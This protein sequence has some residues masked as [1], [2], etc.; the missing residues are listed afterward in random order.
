MKIFK[1]NQTKRITAAAGASLLAAAVVVSSLFNSTQAAENADTL[2]GIE[3]LRNQMAE[4]GEYTILEIVPDINASEIGYFFDGYEPILSEWDP[5]TLT[6]RSWEDIICSM[7]T[8]EK[9]REFITRKKLELQEYYD[10]QGIK[11]EVPVTISNV[12]YNDSDS[13]VEG[14]EEIEGGSF[15]ANGYFIPA[16]PANN[17]AVANGTISNLRD[18]NR[19]F[20]SFEYVNFNNTPKQDDVAYYRSANNWP[21]SEADR[22]TIPDGAYIYTMDG[23]EYYCIGTWGENKDTILLSSPGGGGSSG[24]GGNTGNDTES[25][26]GEEEDPDS[27]EDENI[28]IDEG[29]NTGDGEDETVGGDNADSN[30]SENETEGGENSEIGGDDAENSGS[31]NESGENDAEINDSATNN[32]VD[33]SVAVG[34]SFAQFNWVKFVSTTGDIVKSLDIDAA[35]DLDENDSSDS[36]SK[37][38]TDSNQD[39]DGGQNGGSD[40]SGSAQDD[41]SDNSGSGQNGGSDGD[42]DG[43]NDGSDGSGDGQNSGSDGSGGNEGGDSGDSD[44]NK[45]DDSDDNKDNDSDNSEDD[46]KDDSD[47][48]DDEPSEDPEEENPDDENKEPDEDSDKDAD[49]DLNKRPGNIFRGKSIKAQDSNNRAEQYYLVFFERIEEESNIAGGAYVVNRNTDKYPIRPVM[50]GSA[51]E[52]STNT[53]GQFYFVETSGNHTQT[54]HFPGRLLYCTGAFHNN[55][56]FKQYVINMTKENFDNFKAKVITMTPDDLNKIY[57]NGTEE[58]AQGTLPEFD[59]LYLNS[60]LRPYHVD[61]AGSTDSGDSGSGS[62]GD[63]T[64]GDGNQG[65]EDDVPEGGGDQSS[66]DAVPEG[67]DD[68]SSGDDVAGG[69]DDQGSGDDVTGD[70]ENQGSGDDVTGGN[71][72]G[73]S[74]DLQESDTGNGQEENSGGIQE[75]NSDDN[76]AGTGSDIESDEESDNSEITSDTDT[77]NNSSNA[78]VPLAAQYMSAWKTYVS[79]DDSDNVESD[80]SEESDNSKTEESATPSGSDETDGSA[81]DT[82]GDNNNDNDTIGDAGTSGDVDGNDNTSS[83]DNA[84]TDTDNDGTTGDTAGTDDDGTTSDPADTDADSTTGD[85]TDSD[86]SDD[87]DTTDSDETGNTDTD[88]GNIPSSDLVNNNSSY[89]G[90]PITVYNTSNSDLSTDVVRLLFNKVASAALPC[91]VDG[92]ILYGKSEGGAITDKSENN[93]EN[94]EMFRLAA[95]LCQPTLEKDYTSVSKADLLAGIEDGDKNFTTEQVYCR[96]GNGK[97]SIIND[98]FFKFTIYEEGKANEVEEGFQNVLDE[99]NLENLYRESDSSGQYKSLS[100]NIAQA[101]AVRHIINYQNR[102]NVDTKKKIKVLEIQPALTTKAELDL[103][104]IQK[105]APGVEDVETTIMTTSEF[106]G[107]IEKINEVYDLVYI[108]TSKEHLNISNWITDTGISSDKDNKYLGST[109]Y[110][111]SEMDGLIYSNIGDKRVVYLPMSGLLDSEYRRNYDG[112]T[113]YYNFVRYSGNDITKEKKDALISFLNG[114]YPI[115]ISDEFIEQPVTVFEDEYFGGRRATLGVGTY[116]EKD[117]LDNQVYSAANTPAKGISSIQVKEGYQVTLYAGNDCTG[118]YT[119]IDS[120]T[121]NLDNLTNLTTPSK[122]TWNNRIRSMSVDKI[123]GA[124]PVKAIDGNH[125]DNSSYLYEFVDTALKKKYTNFYAKGDIDETGSELF[126]FYLNRAKASLVN[127]SANGFKGKSGE[128]TGSEVNEA[129]YI[130]PNAVGRYTLQFNFTIQNEGAASMDTRYYCK[131]YIDVNADGKFSEFEEVSDIVML[132]R[133]SGG[134]VSPNELYAGTAYTITRDVPTGYKGLLPWKIEVCQVNNENIYASQQGYTKLNGLDKE[135][136]RICQITKDGNDVI[137]LNHEINTEGTYFYTLVNGGVGPDGKTYDGI[138]DDFELD[139][140]TI[141]ISEYEAE[142]AANAHY[143]DNFNMLILGFSD[144]Y[145]DFTGDSNSGAMGAIVDFINSGKSVLL[146]HDTTSFFNNPIIDGTELGWT[147][148]DST[149]AQSDLL[150]YAGG[151]SRF[152]ATLNKYVRPLVGMDRYGVLSSSIVK[153]GAALKDGQDGWGDLVNSTKDAAYKPKS[154]RKE[155]VPEAQGYTYGVITA[156]DKRAYNL[157][158]TDIE[159]SK[160][161]MYSSSTPGFSELGPFRNDY[162]S[163]RFDDSYYWDNVK[164]N[165]EM[166]VVNNGEVDKVHVTQVNQ[167]QIT[168]YPYKLDEEFEVGLTH[169]QYY[170]LDYTADDDGDKQSDLVV[171][172]CLGGRTSS[173]KAKTQTIYSQSPNDVRNNYYI[174]NKGNITYTGMGHSAGRDVKYTFNEAKLFINTMIASYQAGVKPPSITVLESGLPEA[175]QLTTMYRYYDEINMISLADAVSSGEY[176]RVYFTVRDLNFVKGTR[177]ID[178]KVY[179]H[180]DGAGGTD[181]ITI[182]GEEIYVNSLGDRIFDVATET[183]NAGYGLNSGDIYYIEVPKSI[184]SNCENGLDIYFEAQ[185]TIRTNTTNENVYTTGKVYAKLQVLRA[186]LFELD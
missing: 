17:A 176:E 154:G 151:D 74:D 181:I 135:I 152:A 163:Q 88:D 39:E 115:V 100:T 82:S 107:H 70:D 97:D 33:A 119:I 128:N 90:Y 132:N 72:S 150:G 172:Y 16:T 139:V 24:G 103:K 92:S 117:L 108:G 29:E 87:T 96:L 19:Y 177:E 183:M 81:T 41:D 104:Q 85:N 95:M 142:F 23:T 25:G 180:V 114:S 106:I 158:S 170:Q 7:D 136:L 13:Y 101:E 174:Y 175:S 131:L 118:E 56:W 105:W 168:E 122:L 94:T 5:E 38:V 144:M 153:R 141:N 146:A 161:N 93:T 84:A 169:S 15:D 112:R 9:R 48:N 126:K 49:K 109:I 6:W 28:D 133:N 167:G 120:K 129:Y 134:I 80:S 47:E 67:S 186:Y 125:I 124:Q 166:N 71:S 130:Y 123:E 46:K 110:N 55:E 155:S 140:T 156:K 127:F 147:Q 185:S 86:G 31:E 75:D 113:Y 145:G 27:G 4:G 65:S 149:N 30:G 54:Y 165:G 44:N 32:T 37:G 10:A 14:Y 60:G 69:G 68:Q 20:V 137:N 45:G 89:Y 148:R 58:Y 34:N 159:F 102:R 171:W 53:T 184:L 22:D 36:A 18:S 66:G 1:S 138:L 40:N 98:N 63:G 99:I 21:L 2:M 64:G 42:G 164:D 121:A 3:K 50:S 73:G 143:L 61:I 91:L 77:L 111:D 173:D 160:T 179:Y 11:A 83:N 26:N 35:A 162:A 62:G 57:Q 8:T 78:K 12:G 182:D 178:V 51:G 76:K 59:F 52:S 43:Q 79:Q 116:Y 157:N